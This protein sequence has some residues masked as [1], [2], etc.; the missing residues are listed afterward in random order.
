MP[1]T[2]QAFVTHLTD[3]TFVLHTVTFYARHV[4]DKWQG[5]G[6][7]ESMLSGTPPDVSSRLSP[8]RTSLGANGE[9]GGVAPLPAGL[10]AVRTRLPLSIGLSLHVWHALPS[11]PLHSHLVQ[12]V[13]VN[14]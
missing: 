8:A 11:R 14:F 6:L 3:S 1:T 12:A 10:D 2:C 4:T 5:A 7:Q 13:R 9:A